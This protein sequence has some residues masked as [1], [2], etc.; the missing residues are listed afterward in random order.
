M[1]TWLE[2]LGWSVL[3]AAMVAAS[4][5]FSGM[6]ATLMA[7]NRVWLRHR[8]KNPADANTKRIFAL[9]EDPRLVLAVS[10][11]GSIIASTGATVVLVLCLVSL[12]HEGRRPLQGETALV[13]LL[14]AIPVL[15]VFGE[16]APRRFFRRRGAKPASWLYYPMRWAIAALGP[17][18]RAGIAT[19]QLVTRR[20][21]IGELP[22]AAL[23]HSEPWE[24][25]VESEIGG[26][27]P[28]PAEEPS[29][30]RMIHGVFDLQRTRVREVM[31]PLVDLVALRL[32]AR[33]AEIRS[34]AR[35]TGYSRFPVYRDRITNLIGYV[36]IYDILAAGAPDDDPAERYL[37]EAFYVPETKRLDDLLQE[38]LHN[39]HKVAIVV[40]EYGGCSGWVTREDL[41]EE[42]VGEIEDEFDKATEPIRRL[43]DHTYLVPAAI[44]IDDLNEQLD[45]NLP[46]GTFDTLGGFVYDKLGRIPK[47]GDSFDDAGVHY[48]VTQ[49]KGR[50]IA[51][52]RITKPAPDA[53]PAE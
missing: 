7:A 45:L 25:L 35:E 36:D 24:S 8:L 52:V 47:V 27:P 6:A 30:T 18:A 51:E 50:R 48:E 17:L 26:K 2:P 16:V 19:A 44:N 32:P 20:S 42:I 23:A 53:S 22:P 33:I 13:A 4:G 10:L 41:L 15:L 21:G 9:F 28:G 3:F 38:M 40:D 1:N 37:R 34:L 11:V 39:H 46:S 14:V 12:W 43:D 31:R 49:M 29:E 5:F